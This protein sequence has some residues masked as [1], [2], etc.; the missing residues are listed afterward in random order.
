[1]F[2]YKIIPLGNSFL[3]NLNHVG[4]VDIKQ[5]YFIFIFYLFCS[6]GNYLQ[7][8][9]SKGRDSQPAKIHKNYEHNRE[10]LTNFPAQFISREEVAGSKQMEEF[11][12]QEYQQTEMNPLLQGKTCLDDITMTFDP[13][14]V[15]QSLQN[16]LQ[17]RSPTQCQYAA[18]EEVFRAL[19]AIMQISNDDLGDTN[20]CTME[21]KP[22]SCDMC[23]KRFKSKFGF[24]CHV[25]SHN[26]L[27]K[28]CCD[29]CGKQ[30]Q[31]RYNLNEHLR[32]NHS[33]FISGH[34][35]TQK[36]QI[37]FV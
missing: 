30:Y 16:S 2:L 11:V 13:L 23:G 21:E 37:P 7:K 6:K 36:R 34:S 35:R 8:D 4:W 5:F 27:Y 31:Q 20:Q 29:L 26:G 28:F 33:I 9:S 15:Q 10:K 32:T 12:S 17:E 3:S 24:R 25:N 22:F 1:M 14:L 19:P 18:K